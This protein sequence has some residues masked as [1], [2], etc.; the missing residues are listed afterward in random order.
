[1][2]MLFEGG[3]WSVLQVIAWAIVALISLVLGPGCWKAYKEHV[4]LLQGEIDDLV[5]SLARL[6]VE[7]DELRD[8]MIA[9]RTEIEF[10]NE[11][12]T[13]RLADERLH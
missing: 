7:R 1:M 5:N 6:K 11:V 8:D 12:I 4:E 10:L 9:L 3:G 2:D 13:R